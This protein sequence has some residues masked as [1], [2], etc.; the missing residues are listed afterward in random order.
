MILESIFRGNFA[1]LD[2]V[3]PDDPDYKKLNLEISAQRDQLAA[4]LT[5]DECTLL[6]NMVRNIYTAQ[7]MEC[8]SYF[9]FGLS[10]G[11]QIQKEAAAQL[12]TRFPEHVAP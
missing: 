11:M 9:T 7:L 3:V 10:A 12:R 8:E 4:R 1:P 2:L 6:D 5:R